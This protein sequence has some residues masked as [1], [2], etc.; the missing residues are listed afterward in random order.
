[1]EV[2]ESMKA[3]KELEEVGVASLRAYPSSLQLWLVL[4]GRLKCSSSGR[5]AK[6][7]MA[8]L[9]KAFKEALK[10]VPVKVGYFIQ[11]VYLL[12]YTS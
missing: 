6:T 12:L 8:A 1:M 4:L 9:E 11:L 7:K 2:L 5:G 3:V 10:N